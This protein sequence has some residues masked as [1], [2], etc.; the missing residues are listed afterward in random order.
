M[1]SDFHPSPERLTSVT[2][3]VSVLEAALDHGDLP[4]G[5]CAANQLVT[6]TT[7]LLDD[8]RHDPA[9]NV[10][11]TAALQVYRNAAFAFRGLF[12]ATEERRAAM[13]AACSTLLDQGHDHL[14][15]FA[16]EPRSDRL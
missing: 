2:R 16:R 10:Q 1:R 9:A 15:R 4:A 12:G 11:L 7:Q 8:L 6:T 13:A 14:E 3:L 5:L